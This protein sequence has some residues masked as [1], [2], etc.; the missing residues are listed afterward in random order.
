MDK[1][2]SSGYGEKSLGTNVASSYQ[3]TLRR[4]AREQQSQQ[5]ASARDMVHTHPDSIYEPN[6][7]D[8]KDITHETSMMQHRTAHSRLPNYL[9]SSQHIKPSISFMSQGRAQQKMNHFVD[10]QDGPSS[11]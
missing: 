5:A 1:F 10:L 2:L 4:A 6:S 8:D 9:V 3:A 11:L 7:M